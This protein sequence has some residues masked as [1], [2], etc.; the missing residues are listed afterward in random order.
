MASFHNNPIDGYHEVGKRSALI[1]VVMGL[2]VS[3]CLALFSFTTPYY[4][5][6]PYH[7]YDIHYYFDRVTYSPDI[8]GNITYSKCT[9]DPSNQSCNTLTSMSTLLI[10]LIV[11]SVLLIAILCI[12]ITKRIISKNKLITTV[13]LLLYL[14]GI[15]WCWCLI[16]ASIHLFMKQFPNTKYCSY[17]GDDT[18]CQWFT[19][20]KLLLSS[21]C[22]LSVLCSVIIG[23]TVPF[24]KVF[25]L[26]PCFSAHDDI[27]IDI[28]TEQRQIQ[29][30]APDN[31]VINERLD[32]TLI[33]NVYNP[34]KR[35]KIC[36]YLSIPE[37]CSIVVL[38]VGLVLINVAL[39]YA[40]FNEWY[41]SDYEA[42][43]YVDNTWNNAQ[44]VALDG[45]SDTPTIYDAQNDDECSF[46]YPDSTGHYNGTFWSCCHQETC[47]NAFDYTQLMRGYE[48][49]TNALSYKCWVDMKAITKA[50]CHPNDKWFV[51]DAFNISQRPMHKQSKLII[52]A[53]FCKQTYDHCAGMTWTNPENGNKTVE[54]LWSTYDAFCEDG[55]GT[56]VRFEAFTDRCFAGCDQYELYTVIF[57]VCLM[58]VYGI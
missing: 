28:E 54:K 20:I 37:C 19:G 3:G 22:L 46:E 2:V 47:G 24:C 6:T 13:H 14:I 55:L 49:D 12:F 34:D 35:R 33:T 45:Y 42:Q 41:P 38:S 9:T 58:I 25:K 1:C 31:I 11:A 18:G 32:A 23:I 15:I 10:L 8:N 17:N 39:A 21:T 16:T 43:K 26:L 53:L 27:D 56:E 50:S 40:Y 30:D 7:G 5:S 4:V 48:M 51:Q 44:C 57:T 29:M 52:C 36:A